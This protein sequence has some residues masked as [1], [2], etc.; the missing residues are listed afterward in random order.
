VVPVVA[1]RAVAQVIAPVIAPVVLVVL[2]LAPLLVAPVASDALEQPRARANAGPVEVP[3]LRAPVDGPVTEPF[4]AV[5]RY[6]PGHRGVDLAA[7]PGSGVR[8]PL[9]GRVTF[10]GAVAGRRWVTVA[11][12]DRVAVTVGPLLE[13]G[14]RAGDRVVAGTP[15]G[16]SDAAHGLSALHLSVRI[17]GVH[18]DPAPH[19]VAPVV[20]WRASLLPDA[21]TA[22]AT[23]VGGE[24]RTGAGPPRG[25]REPAG[26]GHS[27]RAAGNAAVP[28]ARVR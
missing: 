16:T 1:G 14:V 9:A 22:A 10:A 27:G 15:L 11:P 12:D 19:L 3:L 24:V 25:A 8:S 17:D 4:S 7:P 13:V 18:V 6:G 26:S 20:P 2:V 21:G 5:D 23:W 28:R